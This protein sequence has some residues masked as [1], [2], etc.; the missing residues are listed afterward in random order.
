MGSLVLLVPAYS[1]TYAPLYL[2]L[3]QET[4]VLRKRRK[5]HCQNLL[6]CLL[7]EKSTEVQPLVGG[8]LQNDGLTETG[9]YIYLEVNPI[10]DLYFSPVK[11]KPRHGYN[12]KYYSVLNEKP[13]AAHQYVSIQA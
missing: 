1:S 10:E 5:K 8:R 4:S 11:N 3:N 13:H 6:P 12:S 2:V 7:S 9:R